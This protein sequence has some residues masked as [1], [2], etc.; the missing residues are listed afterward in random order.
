MP[1]IVIV[2]GGISGLALA[3]RLEQLSPNLEV[4]LI[5]REPRLGGTVWTLSEDDFQIE[6]GPNGFLDNKPSTLALCK[7][8]GLADKLVPASEAAGRNR[9][10]F[11][12]NKL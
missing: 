1:K 7:A 9:F 5:E 11:L 4:T 10:V 3:F 8:L 12:K 2:G 6:I